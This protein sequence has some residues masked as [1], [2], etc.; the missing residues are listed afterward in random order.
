MNKKELINTIAEKAQLK[1]KDATLFVEA[2]VDVVT[3][4]LIDGEDVRL[5]G[6]GTFKTVERAE[7]NGYNPLNGE[8]IIIAAKK[9]P[10]FKAGKELKDVVKQG[11]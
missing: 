1:K 10:V 11:E 3:E 5:I 6:F 2:F 8:K 7:R 9:A 4:S